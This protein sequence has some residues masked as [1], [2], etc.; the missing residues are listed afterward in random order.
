MNKTSF[1]FKWIFFL[2]LGFT[3]ACVILPGAEIATFPTITPVRTSTPIIPTEAPPKPTPTPKPIP[4]RFAVI[5]DYGDGGELE[6][7][8]AILVRSWKPDFVI[9]TGDNNYPLGRKRTIDNHIGQFYADFIYPYYG[10]FESKA[11]ANRFFPTLGNHDLMTNQGEAYLE[12][13]TLPGNERYYTFTWD[14][15]QLFALNSNESEPD[16]FRRDSTQAQWLENEME[17]SESQWQ[18]VYLHQPPYS[19]GNHGSSTYMRWPFK[20]WDADLVISGHDHTYERLDVDGLTYIV[21]GLGGHSIYDFVDVLPESQV[22]YN[23]GFG[24]MLVEAYPERMVI[25]FMNTNHEIVDLFEIPF[26]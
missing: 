13:F 11:E 24:A 23:N 12:Y 3:L 7:I 22:R 25:Q 18:I 26:D 6:G 14:F 21:N 19:S 17:R 10:E 4:V 5:G 2:I 15:V 20:E 1:Q 16:G 8:V 9:T